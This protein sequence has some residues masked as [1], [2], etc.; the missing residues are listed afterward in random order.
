METK[1]SNVFSAVLIKKDGKPVQNNRNNYYHRIVMRN[2][3][4]GIYESIKDIQTA[5]VPGKDVEYEIGQVPKENNPNETYTKI[6]P[7]YK[8][9]Q[10][11]EEKPLP[12]LKTA[13]EVSEA[14][15]SVIAEE[16]AHK[17]IPT[18]SLTDVAI[19]SQRRAVEAWLGNGIGREDIQSFSKEMSEY[20]VELIGDL[21][22]SNV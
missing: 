17:P 20:L 11:Q 6:K 9:A 14:L 21:N 8:K 7:I 1:T 22:R 16:Q 12:P 5:F 3:D 10:V 18:Y 19:A 4:V 13:A 15:N 2:K